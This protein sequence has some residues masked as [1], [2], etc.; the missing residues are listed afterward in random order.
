MMRGKGWGVIEEMGRVKIYRW[1]KGNRSID[2]IREEKRIK[3]E[4]TVKEH[5]S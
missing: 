3:Q 2:N 5:R 1:N 4:K